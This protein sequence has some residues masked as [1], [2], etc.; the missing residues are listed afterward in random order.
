M[1]LW[2]TPATTRSRFPALLHRSLVPSFP[3]SLLCSLV[4][5][6]PRHLVTFFPRS[7]LLHPLP[8]YP[9][10]LGISCCTVV[11]P[12]RCLF[13]TTYSRGPDACTPAVLLYNASNQHAM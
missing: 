2:K 9:R 12:S 10:K 1:F 5:S 8:P 6:S 7:L 4:P 3:R 11:Q 13:T